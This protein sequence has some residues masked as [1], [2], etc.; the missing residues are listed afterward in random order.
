M[1][2]SARLIQLQLD[3]AWII[4]DFEIEVST[5]MKKIEFSVSLGVPSKGVGPQGGG[6]EFSISRETRLY[7]KDAI[8]CVC[9]F[10]HMYKKRKCYQSQ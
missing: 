1:F 8:L 2:R 6:S 3:N 10:L 7:K 9:F 4:V 5:N